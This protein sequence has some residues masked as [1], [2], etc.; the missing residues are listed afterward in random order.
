MTNEFTRENRI[1][2]LDLKIK[3]LAVHL[4]AMLVILTIFTFIV[5]NSTY[6][7]LH[8]LIISCVLAAA[9]LYLM[10]SLKRGNAE[11]DDIFKN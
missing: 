4:T 5:G 7:S 11:I 3:H 10:F 9:M 8:K 2:K 1:K 6:E